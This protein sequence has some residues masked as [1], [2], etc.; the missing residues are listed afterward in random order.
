MSSERAHGGALQVIRPSAPGGK[1][2]PRANM[3]RAQ[4]KAVEV[5]HDGAPRLRVL[6]A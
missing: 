4:R 6:E 3:D 2:L 5:L 1:C